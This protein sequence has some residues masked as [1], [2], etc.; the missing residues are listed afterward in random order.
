MGLSIQVVTAWLA[1]SCGSLLLPSTMKE[2]STS[3]WEP[4]KRSNSKL[5]MWFLLKLHLFCTIINS[6]NPKWNQ[7][8]SGTVCNGNIHSETD[9]WHFVLKYRFIKE[10]KYACILSFLYGFYYL[11]PNRGWGE[12]FCHKIFLQVDHKTVLRYY[13]LQPPMK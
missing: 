11:Q 3:Y 9:R 7:Q 6:K 2:N 10:K 1:E 8:K 5:K 4:R 12:I 13:I